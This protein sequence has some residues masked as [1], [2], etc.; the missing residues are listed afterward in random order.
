MRIKDA[1]FYEQEFIVVLKYN[2]SVYLHIISDIVLIVNWFPDSDL[3][4]F[5]LMS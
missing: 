1:E 2:K 4:L 3:I 5:F